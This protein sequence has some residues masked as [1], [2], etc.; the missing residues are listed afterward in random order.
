MTE[1]DLITDKDMLRAAPPDILLTNYKMLDYLL[2]RPRDCPA[3]A[4]NEPTRCGTWWWMSCTLSM[5]RRARI[6]ACLIRRI[7]ERVRTPPN[8][9]C[10]VGTSATLGEGSQADLSCVRCGSFS[11]EP[12]DDDSV[13]GESLLT[14][15]E[16]LKGCLVTRFQTPGT[17]D[18]GATGPVGL[19]IGG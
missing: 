6:S 5:E 15:D 2:V 14:P 8:H 1:E 17:G 12:F 4:V 19:R 13:I 7:K 11:A 9:L 3:V 16:F 18:N 10:C